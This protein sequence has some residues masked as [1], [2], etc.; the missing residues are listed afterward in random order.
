V[1]SDT[2]RRSLAS[3]TT[4]PGARQSFSDAEHHSFASEHVCP[5]TPADL[6][7]CKT[8]FLSNREGFARLPGK[9]LLL[10]ILC[11]SSWA[12]LF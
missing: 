4:Y 7:C 10:Q 8:P 5:G 12:E 6:F 11:A 3:K 1:R 2:H 9:V